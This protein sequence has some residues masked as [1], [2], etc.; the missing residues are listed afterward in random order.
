LTS[1][2]LLRSTFKF[3]QL[4]HKT[5]EDINCYFVG[6]KL[7]TSQEVEELVRASQELC[8]EMAPDALAICESFGLSE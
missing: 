6:S 8:A 4:I 2:L 1:S 5:S 3:I 7:M